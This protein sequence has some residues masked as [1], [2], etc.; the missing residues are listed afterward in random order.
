MYTRYVAYYIHARTVSDGYYVNA[1]TRKKE[2]GTELSERDPAS[3]TRRRLEV[4]CPSMIERAF[5]RRD[6]FL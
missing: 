2:S 4:Q 1:M 3:E 6:G 5:L